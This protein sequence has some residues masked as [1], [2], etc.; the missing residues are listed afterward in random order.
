MNFHISTYEP[1]IVSTGFAVVRPRHIRSNFLAY[2]LK[3]SSFVESVVARSVGVS[4]PAVNASEIGDITIP[5]PSDAEQITLADFLDRETGRIDTL[6]AKK[7]KLVELLKEKRSALIS[8]AVTR[9]LPADASREFGLE[10]HT[11]FKQSDIEWLGEVPAHWEVK[12]LRYVCRFAY[13]DSLSAEIREEGNVAVYGSNGPVGSHIT[14]NTK[15]PVII[16]GRKGSF[17]KINYSEQAVFAI[18]TTY[19]VDSS[20][21]KNYLGWLKYA[22]SVLRLDESS[23]DSAVPGLAREDAYLCKLSVPPKPEQTTIADFLDRE[24]AKIDR[25]VEKVEA[26]MARLQEYRSALITA[27]VTGKIDVREYV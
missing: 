13:G 9:G 16:V 10:P 8:R 17:G 23:K 20:C 6:V 22:F 18:D 4:Y 2:A 24:T 25:L 27:A 21:T 1:L 11:S 26:A 14:A 15:N 19:Y 7:R 5:L 12:G 3:E